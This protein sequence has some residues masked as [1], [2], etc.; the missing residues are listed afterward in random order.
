MKVYYKIYP[1]N[2]KASFVTSVLS[3]YLLSSETKNR[4]N[5]LEI[6]RYLQYN[7]IGILEFTDL[8]IFFSNRCLLKI[9]FES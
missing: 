3:R 2:V 6:L 9:F 5:F 7:N 8:I 1:Y 4:C